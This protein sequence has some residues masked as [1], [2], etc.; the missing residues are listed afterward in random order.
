[1]IIKETKTERPYQLKKPILPTLILISVIIIG[2]AGYNILWRDANSSLI[3]ELYMTLVTITT[4]GFGEIHPL[5]TSGRIFT[6]V[7]AVFGIG[8]LFYLLGILMEN[9][10][11]IQLFNYRGIKKM[12]KKIDGFSNH[13]I[14]VGYGRVGKL[15]ASELIK[16][17]EQFVIIDEH[18]AE[19]SEFQSSKSIFAIV[20]DATEDE[21]LLKAGIKHARCLIMTT[22]NPTTTVFVTLS[23]RVLNPEI[24]IVARA[25]EDN[26]IGKIQRAGADRIVNPYSIGGQRLAGVAI[27]PK[28]ID[29][30]DTSFSITKGSINFEKIILPKD[31]IWINKSLKELDIR[32]KSGASVLAVIRNNSPILNPSGN[33]IFVPGDEVM[34]IGSQDQIQKL[35]SSLLL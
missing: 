21:T 25:D 12:L 15:A 29:F 22:A 11:V 27:N 33:F 3:D 13:I 1:M 7:I 4:I 31:S 32:R 6:M 34:I 19:I 14:L 28:L 20:G 35:Q 17:N 18:F 24:F 23:A 5:S 16:N 8:S 30:I 26:A 10:V 2:T 9:L